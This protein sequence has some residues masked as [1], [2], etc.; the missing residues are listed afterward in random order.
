MDTVSTINYEPIENY[1]DK[2]CASTTFEGIV[3]SFERLC[4]AANLRSLPGSG[5]FYKELRQRLSFYW[6][7]EALFTNLDVRFGETIYG[8]QTICQN[9]QVTIISLN[10]KAE[11]YIFLKCALYVFTI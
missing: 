5:Q 4:D 1:F 3:A 9:I 2:F 8:S 6:K 11:K 10:Y 7:A